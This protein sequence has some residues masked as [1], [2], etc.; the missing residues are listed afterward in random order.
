MPPYLKRYVKSV[1]ARQSLG[2]RASSALLLTFDDG[3]HP[4]GTPAV[5][6]VLRSHQAR[7]V[8]FVVGSRIA[9]A[10]ELLNRILQEGHVIGN[11]S[12]AHPLGSQLP[13]FSYVSDL[14]K[15]QDAISDI[16]GAR[17]LL[18][19]PPLGHV[20]FASMGAP[21]VLGLRP[22][23]WTIDTEDWRFADRTDADRAADRIA[24]LCSDR[25]VNDIVLMHDEK[26]HT[27]EMLSRLL[28]QLARQGVD[29]HD[30][31]DEL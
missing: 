26:I 1:L 12:F 4:V 19:R 7:A 24:A 2:A 23:L 29:L 8:F 28:P 22:V 25:V 30:A 20:S 3:P 13:F 9:R 27:A 6:E 15:C 10:P 31:V 18:F 16:T 17:P 21:R 11:H 5:L 14:R